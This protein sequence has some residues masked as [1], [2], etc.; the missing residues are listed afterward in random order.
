MRFRDESVI[1]S[2]YSS[3]THWCMTRDERPQRCRHAPTLTIIDIGHWDIDTLGHWRIVH[4]S[5]CDHC[6]FRGRW[7]SSAAATTS[8]PR[9]SSTACTTG[10]RCCRP[11]PRGPSWRFEGSRVGKK[12]FDSQPTTDLRCRF[13]R[14]LVVFSPFLN[15]L[16]PER[17][18]CTSI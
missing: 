10:R 4:L 3:M 1:N 15:P 8:A 13:S 9:A 14:L 16:M 12:K 6:R 5:N 18:F 2:L 17:Y 7:P 11:S